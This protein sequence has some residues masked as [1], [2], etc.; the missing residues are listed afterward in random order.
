MKTETKPTEPKIEAKNC[1]CGK[2]ALIVRKVGG[3]VISYPKP[4]QCIG[5]YF[6]SAKTKGVAIAN[7]NLIV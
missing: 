4:E 3:Y 7:W 6:T 1:K 5:N 2:P